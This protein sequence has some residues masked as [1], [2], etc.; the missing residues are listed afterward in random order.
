METG[1]EIRDEPLGLDCGLSAGLG[2]VFRPGFSG[3]VS[4]YCLCDLRRW[5]LGLSVH[6][7]WRRMEGFMGSKAM[8]APPCS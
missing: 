1:L 2:D 5:P 7:C 4:P 8:T 6:S 3:S